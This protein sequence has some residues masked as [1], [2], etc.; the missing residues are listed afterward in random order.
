MGSINNESKM[1]CV[2]L[3]HQQFTLIWQLIAGC[4][5]PTALAMNMISIL[6]FPK[7]NP[8]K[9]NY[10]I[11]EFISYLSMHFLE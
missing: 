9:H 10:I 5:L 11:S 2:S 1:S 7:K 3:N 6:I 4:K 8:N